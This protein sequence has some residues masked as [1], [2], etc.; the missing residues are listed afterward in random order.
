[1]PPYTGRCGCG[2]I[3][4]RLTA[5]PLMVGYCH[6][7]RCQRRT[8]CAASAQA[9]IDGRDLDIVTGEDLI[10]AWGHPDGGFLKLF[11]SVCG[12]HVF[13][14]SPENPAQMSVRMGAFD[15]GHSLRPSYRQFTAY[16]AEWEPIPDDGLIRHA[17]SANRPLIQ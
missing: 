16:A 14:R 17:E 5:E 15:P 2:A 7:T 3:T 12:S 13:S 6:C 10:S 1:M 11:C 8:G 4:F 9:R